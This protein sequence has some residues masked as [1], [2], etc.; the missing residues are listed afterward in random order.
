MRVGKH[1]AADALFRQA[2]PLCEK[3]HGETSYAVQHTLEEMAGCYDEM[4]RPADA[5]ALRAR[6][7]E[8]ARI[9]PPDGAWY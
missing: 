9:R 4:N 5:Q 1:T 2:L 8:L 7:A 3:Y 6:A